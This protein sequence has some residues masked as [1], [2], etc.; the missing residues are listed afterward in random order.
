M[1]QVA[2]DLGP[3][4]IDEFARI[5]GTTGRNV[6]LY[7][8][9]Q[10]L[11]PP[12]RH[13]RV[14]LYGADHLRRLRLILRLLD[15]GYSLAAIGELVGAWEENRTLGDV[16][17]FEEALAAFK[18]EQP[19]AF[20][21]EQLGELFPTDDAAEGLRRAVE[22]GILVP[23]G[24]ELVAPVPSLLAVGAEL[25][26]AGVPLPPRG[27]DQRARPRNE[28]L[29]RRPVELALDAT[30]AAERGGEGEAVRGV[31]EA[32][33]PRQREAD[34]RSR[35]GAVRVDDVEVAL[36]IERPQRPDGGQVPRMRRAPQ[37]ERVQSMSLLGELLGHRGLGTGRDLHLPAASA[38]PLRE[39][40][41][42]LGDPTVERAERLKDP[43]TAVR[44]RGGAHAT[45]A[46]V[47]RNPSSREV[48]AT[49]PRRSRT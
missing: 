11:P 38:Q 19:Q 37:P 24:D 34:E 49:H 13:G 41:N 12:D 16:L 43:R 4:P 28:R 2:D 29:L 36:A 5:A 32:L 46:S 31:D 35:L 21:T 20:T 47:R 17:G 30:H 42:V 39:A 27:G 9:R 1:S 8:T 14:G 22:L 45:A 10:L 6:R 7:Q 40:Q 44:R 48:S 15:R 3:W 33:A 23:R 18:T 25:V 26:A